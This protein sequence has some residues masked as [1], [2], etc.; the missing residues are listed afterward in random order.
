MTNGLKRLVHVA[1]L[2]CH[3]RI[4]QHK[5]TCYYVH[6]ALDIIFQI[7]ILDCVLSQSQNVDSNIQLSNRPTPKQLALSQN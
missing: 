5:H 6:C 7:F 2:S 1:R 3:S 4:V